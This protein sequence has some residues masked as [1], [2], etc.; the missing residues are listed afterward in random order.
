[1][2]GNPLDVHKPS[3]LDVLHEE[4]SQSD[5]LGPFVEAKLVAEAE[6]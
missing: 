5:V 1:M 4:V 3:S 2:G 6:S